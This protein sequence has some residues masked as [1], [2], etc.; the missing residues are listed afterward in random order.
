MRLWFIDEPAMQPVYAE[1]GVLVPPYSEPVD[2][3]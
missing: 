3:A 2:L 1:Q